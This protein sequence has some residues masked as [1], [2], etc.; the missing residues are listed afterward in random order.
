MQHDGDLAYTEWEA[1]HHLTTTQCA[2]GEE[3]KR[4]RLMEEE[5]RESTERTFQA[6]EKPLETVT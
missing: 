3:R 6:Y 2:K 4:W 1:P 5:M